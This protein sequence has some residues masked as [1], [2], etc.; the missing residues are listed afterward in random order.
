MQLKDNHIYIN[1][2]GDVVFIKRGECKKYQSFRVNDFTG[3]QCLALHYDNGVNTTYLKHYDITEEMNPLISV[4]VEL[5]SKEEEP[6]VC[7]KYKDFLYDNYDDA[8]VD[9]KKDCLDSSKTKLEPGFYTVASF[10][11]V[12]TDG[13]FDKGLLNQNVEVL[14]VHQ[15][16]LNDAN[17]LNLIRF[18]DG[19]VFADCPFLVKRV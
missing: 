5:S 11:E 19:K 14:D 7:F 13:K 10:K 18:P 9:V 17:A 6:K 3:K 8:L 1:G 4:L 15:D 16:I 2:R 12:E